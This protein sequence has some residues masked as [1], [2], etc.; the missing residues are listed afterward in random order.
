MPHAAAREGT[1]GVGSRVDEAVA[2]RWPA[3]EVAALLD[4]LH[5]HGD[6]DP[7]PRTD[8]LGLRAGREHREQRL[9]Q[10]TAEPHET[11]RLRQPQLHAVPFQHHAQG[12]ELG[13]VEEGPFVLA[14]HDRVDPVGRIG[15]RAEQGCGLGSLWPGHLAGAGGLE[16]LADDRAVPGGEPA[17][18]VE[19]PRP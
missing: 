5:P 12:I 18:D 2:V 11:T 10:R 17:G 6:R 14:D 15:D 4:G 1:I 3:T 8:H 19:L 13:V 7:V 9:V 16:V